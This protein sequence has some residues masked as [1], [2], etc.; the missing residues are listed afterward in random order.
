MPGWMQTPAFGFTPIF[1][2]PQNPLD[3][4]PVPRARAKDIRPHWLGETF[5]RLLYQTRYRV[6]CFV[7]LGFR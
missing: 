7:D 2:T 1:R 6:K 5:P 3:L 4:W